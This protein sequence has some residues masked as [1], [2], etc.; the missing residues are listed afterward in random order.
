[1]V[2]LPGRG[3]RVGGRGWAAIGAAGEPVIEITGL[4]KHYRRGRGSPVRAVDGLDLVLGQP[5]IVHGFLGPNGS[6]KTTTIRCRLSLIRPTAGTV[7]VLGAE[8]PGTFHQV[9]GRVGA[10]V[11][12]PKLFPAFSARRN[13]SL[14]A[15]MGECWMRPRRG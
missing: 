4:A 10:I 15:R 5:G 2:P 9:A 3:G 7:R 14:L 8:S 11:E 12:T 6:G 1:M 13:L